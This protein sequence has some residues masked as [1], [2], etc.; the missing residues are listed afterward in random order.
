[1]LNFIFEDNKDYNN[2]INC[3]DVNTSGIRRFGKSALLNASHLYYSFNNKP[4]GINYISVNDDVDYYIISTGVNHS[5]DDWTGYNPKVKSLFSYLNEKYLNDLRS[6]KAFLLLDQSLEGYQTKWLWDFFHK[7][8]VEYNISPKQIIYVTGNMIVEDVYNEWVNKNQIKDKL[9]VIG[10]PHFEFDMGRSAYERT[11]T[12]NPLPTI[13]KHLTYKTNNL[14]N[15]KTFA[16]LNKRLR[17][18][19]IW[20]YSYLYESG[21]LDRG[22]VSMN[23]FEIGNYFFEGEALEE[24][25]LK[26]M[27]EKLPLLVH[28]KRNDELDDNFY[29]NRFNDQ[30]CL[31]TF[32]TVISEAHCGDSDETMFLSEKTFKVIACRHPFIIMGNKDSMKKMRQIGYRTFGDMIDERYDSLPTHD[33]LK[34]IVETINKIDHIKDKIEWYKGLNDTIEYNYNVLMTKLYRL[35]DAYVEVQNYINEICLTGK[36]EI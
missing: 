6:G 19:R 31:D 9:K 15:I 2:F 13:E 17:F 20:F 14:E 3:N 25:K 8:C 4:L 12:E 33:R 32:L 1:M 27:I 34:Y 21:L 26:P 35:P 22:L 7:E 28:G 30:I 10:Y 36:K 23:K 29:I 11:K 16:C 18:H 24:D 5:P